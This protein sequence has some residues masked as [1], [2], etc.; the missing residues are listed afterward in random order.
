VRITGYLPYIAGV[1]TEMTP[2]GPR[3]IPVIEPI[4]IRRPNMGRYA[5]AV[6]LEFTGRDELA[7]WHDSLWV[8]FSAYTT[9]DARPVRI[10][11]PDGD[12]SWEIL[13]TRFR[14]PLEAALIPQKLSVTL[15]PGR[16][17]VESW[18]S[19]F[20]V[21][22]GDQPPVQ[23]AVYT[24]QTYV[25]D[26]WTLF[27]SGAAQDHWS[28]TVLGRGQSPGHPADVDR[29]HDDYARMSLYAFYVKPVFDSPTIPA[30]SRSARFTANRTC[31][32][33]GQPDP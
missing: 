6:Q 1:R 3:E 25:L 27:Q 32:P 30:R 13:Y 21:A 16:A 5:S 33:C 28:H 29:L 7:G 15:F 10:S 2:N 4:E 14:R 31:K 8:T 20:L 26:N 9:Q 17:N 19:D 12:Q 23:A 18:R 22:T 11:P 24:N